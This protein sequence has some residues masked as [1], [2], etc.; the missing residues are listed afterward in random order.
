[1]TKGAYFDNYYI[2]LVRNVQAMKGAA[3][4]VVQDGLTTINVTGDFDQ[5]N[6]VPV[7]YRDPSGDT[8]ARNAE[9]FG[10]NV[11]T[12]STGR[13]DIV[14]T[15]VTSDDTHMYF[16]IETAKPIQKYNNASTWMN[17]YL[18][19]DDNASTGWY[20][21]D[22][23]VNYKQVNDYTTQ[24]AKAN[25]NGKTHSFSV[26]GSATMKVNLRKMMV[27]VP[28]SALGIT[29]PDAVIVNFKV[30]DSKSTI[31]TMEG[32]YTDGDVAPL[33][34]LNYVYQNCFSKAT[35]AKR[36]SVSYDANGGTGAPAA[37]IK[38]YGY[39]LNLSTA[40]PTR[41]GYTFKGWATSASATTAQYQPGA[42]YGVDSD[43]KLYAVWGGSSYGVSYNANGGTGAPASQVKAPGVSIKLSTTVPTKAGSTFLGW[44]TS[45]SATTAQY[46]PGATYS[47]DADL[48]LYAVWSTYV[49]GDVTG[50]GSVNSMDL[51][52]MQK[53]ASSGG[54][55]SVTVS[56]FKAADV[57]ADGKF[58]AKD[59]TRLK[60][61]VA[62][63]G[64][65]SVE[66]G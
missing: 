30:A 35:A 22:Y 26:S 56:S 21:Y 9:G 29:D 7:T 12:N 10:T 19:T 6:Q 27:A 46:Q 4:N 48:T 65:G 60:K 18:D 42:Q 51:V 49:V 32:F 43:L 44:A 62:S 15:K 33:G 17:I 63:G 40:V 8:M 53:Y 61:Y 45:P 36:S 14:Y 66:L 47:V 34:R 64:D 20:G 16:Y 3:P 38:T 58:N 39:I 24:I 55:G 52:R 5:W 50:D 37:Q 11:Y 54:D 23:I 57:N 13:N 1:M 25:S 28:L 41:D 59:L 2:Q 31:T